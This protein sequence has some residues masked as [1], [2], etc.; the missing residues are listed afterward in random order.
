[1]FRSLLDHHRQGV[2]TLSKHA[3]FCNKAVQIQV[4]AFVGELL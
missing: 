4:C 3:G 1:M 2:R